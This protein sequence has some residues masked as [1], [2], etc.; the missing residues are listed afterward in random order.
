MLEAQP[1]GP[2]GN[3]AGRRWCGGHV[4]RRRVLCVPDEAPRANNIDM[5]RGYG[6]RFHSKHDVV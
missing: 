3:Q 2:P 5:I 6:L 1:E 4:H